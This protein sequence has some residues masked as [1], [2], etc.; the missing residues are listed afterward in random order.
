VG[1]MYAVRLSPY[2]LSARGEGEDKHPKEDPCVELVGLLL[3]K[4]QTN[5]LRYGLLQALNVCRLNE[6]HVGE[7]AIVFN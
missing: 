6:E 4:A 2:P 3:C 5:S 1:L 7:R